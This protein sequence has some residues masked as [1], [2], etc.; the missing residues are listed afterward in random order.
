M[1]PW[2]GSVVWGLG[3]EDLGEPPLLR[4][5]FQPQGLSEPDGG[6][7]QQDRVV[8]VLDGRDLPVRAEDRSLPG[9]EGSQHHLLPR[10]LVDVFLPRPLRRE[11]VHS[12]LSSNSVVSGVLLLV[13]VNPPGSPESLSFDEPLCDVHTRID[14]KLVNPMI[15]VLQVVLSLLIIRGTDLQRKDGFIKE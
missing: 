1:R 12:C 6:A 15:S 13:G 14:K 5:S 4:P 10:V 9:Q 3:G 11:G 2:S 7:P 8:E